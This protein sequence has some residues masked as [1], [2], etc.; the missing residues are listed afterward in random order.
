MLRM[1]VISAAMLRMPLAAAAMPSLNPA[2]LFRIVYSP[3]CGCFDLCVVVRNV[4]TP[5]RVLDALDRGRRHTV[6]FCL[7]E[8]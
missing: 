7:H 3:L 8:R 4:P 2:A 5:A 6:C 1:P